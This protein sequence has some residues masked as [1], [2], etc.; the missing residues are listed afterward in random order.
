YLDH[1]YWESLPEVVRNAHVWAAD[2]YGSTQSEDAWNRPYHQ[3]LYANVVLDGLT[4]IAVV[5]SNEHKWNRLSG[6]AKFIRAYAFFNLA[7]LFAPPYFAGDSGDGLGIPLRLSSDINERSPRS[8][9][10]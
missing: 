2:L 10:H 1:A 4:K 3:V 8:S 7:Q 5:P 9:V 6:S